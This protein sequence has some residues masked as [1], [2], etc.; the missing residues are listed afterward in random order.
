MFDSLLFDQLID[1]P[2]HIMGVSKSC[3]DSIDHIFTNNN[4]IISEIG[5]RPKIASHHCIVR[6]TL[7]HKI[8]KTHSYKCMV[9]D[10][11]RG[12]YDAFRQLLLH[13]PWYSYHN[14]NNINVVVEN[15]MNIF[16]SIADTCIPHYEA[17]IRPNDKN[18][19][20]SDVRHKINVR[21]CYWKQYQQTNLDKYHDKFKEIRNE[22]VYAIHESKKNIEKKNDLVSK[23]EVGSKKWWSLYKSILNDGVSSTPGPLKDGDIIVTNDLEN[24]NLFIT[25]SFH[26]PYLMTKMLYYLIC[27]HIV[28]I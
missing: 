22:V 12:D 1:Q 8:I 9:W 18:V 23:T 11:K 13:A 6:A 27:P 16:T 15:F 5:I 3:I 21:D 7:K 24:A 19:M 26:K 17:T 10:Y 14:S 4:N 25:L 28:T 20:N 2:T